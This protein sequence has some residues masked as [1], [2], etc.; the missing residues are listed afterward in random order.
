MALVEAGCARLT[1][2]DLTSEQARTTAIADFLLLREK[3]QRLLAIDGVIIGAAVLATA[4]LRNAVLAY[5]D[6]VKAHPRSY[7]NVPPPSFPPEYVLLYG[8]AVSLLLALFWAPIYTML[9]SAG[10]RL[11]KSAIGER[12]KDESWT[13]W[14]ERRA[15]FEQFL[16]VE[17]SAMANFRS[18]VAILTPLGSALLGLLFER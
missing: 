15:K 16:G 18:A 6:E 4:A 1:R 17:T 2:T 10:A 9:V 5:G 7:P 3:L 12:R 11:V 14:Q 8:L 13:D